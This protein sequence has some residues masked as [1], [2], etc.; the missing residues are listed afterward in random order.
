M[1]GYLWFVCV[2]NTCSIFPNS[3]IRN[4]GTRNGISFPFLLFPFALYHGHL[5]CSAA[6]IVVRPQEVPVLGTGCSAHI[7]SVL[8]QLWAG[9]QYYFI[10]L[11]QETGPE[12]WVPCPSL[13]LEL[14]SVWLFQHSAALRFRPKGW[15]N[16]LGVSLWSGYYPFLSPFILKWRPS[17]CRI[18]GCSEHKGGLQCTRQVL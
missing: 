7:S 5:L 17:S 15:I 18:C 14:R 11:E 3:S 1:W 2:D 4:D 9:H 8:A 12:W 10:L 6:Q 13:H 16:D